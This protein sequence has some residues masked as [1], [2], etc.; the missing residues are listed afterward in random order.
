VLGGVV[1]EEFE[2]RVE[3]GEVSVVFA[4]GSFDGDAGSDFEA[5]DAA[6]SEEDERDPAGVVDASEVNVS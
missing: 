1:R 3:D 6:A 5:G 2:D 4:G